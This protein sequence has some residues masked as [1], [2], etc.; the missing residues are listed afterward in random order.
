MLVPCSVHG[1]AIGQ[2]CG[3]KFRHHGG[4]CAAR[5]RLAGLVGVASEV[6][7]PKA[8]AKGPRRIVGPPIVRIAYPWTQP[9]C[10]PCSGLGWFDVRSN[11]GPAARN[12]CPDCKG[13]GIVG[14]LFL[15]IDPA[16]DA[17][18]ASMTYRVPAAHVARW[19]AQ[20]TLSPRRYRVAGLG[21][22][23]VFEWKDRR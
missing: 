10:R 12:T 2:A 22:V 7:A 11:V 14:P 19:G 4:V 20:V 8:T 15:S 21:V 23:T 3:P 17:R 9:H 5:G 13:R 1:A 16:V 18:T 6:L